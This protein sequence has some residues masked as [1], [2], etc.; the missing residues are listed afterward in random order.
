MKFKKIVTTLLQSKELLELFILIGSIQFFYQ[1]F[2]LYWQAIFIDKTIS[3]SIFGIIYV[4][5]SLS[6]IVG[7]WV[8]RRIKHT[9]YDIYIILTIILLL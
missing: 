8:F 7:A 9:K 2:Y 1:P 3:V 4:L 5:F 6:D